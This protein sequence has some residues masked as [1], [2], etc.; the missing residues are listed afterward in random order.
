MRK[1]NQIL[2]KCR[3]IRVQKKITKLIK[4]AKNLTDMTSEIYETKKS[5]LI[6]NLSKIHEYM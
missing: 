6:R 4:E 3:G 1:C 2:L 5:E